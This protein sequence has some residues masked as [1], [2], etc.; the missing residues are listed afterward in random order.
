MTTVNLLPW[1]QA[2]AQRCWRFWGLCGVGTLLILLTSTFALRSEEL[3]L[4]QS[5]NLWLRAS[6]T[7]TDALA[8]RQSQLRQQ[9]DARTQQRARQQQRRMTRRWQQT[10]ETLAGRLPEQAWLTQLQVQQDS[11]TLAGHANTFAALKAPDEALQMLPDFHA[12]RPGNTG[13]DP[14]GRWQFSYQLIREIHHDVQP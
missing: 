9:Q 12:I 6:M 11:L 2:R 4:I 1:R 10:L 5:Q 7:L 8:Q 14:Q 3:A 13:R